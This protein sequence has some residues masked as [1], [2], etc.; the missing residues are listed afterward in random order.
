MALS[1]E[2]GTVGGGEGSG[3]AA[4]SAPSGIVPGTV[5]Q[6]PPLPPAVQVA[7]RRRPLL[8]LLTLLLLVLLGVAALA[9][10]FLPRVGGPAR[11]SGAAATWHRL[12]R[13][14]ASGGAGAAAPAVTER[15]S[16]AAAISA[17]RYPIARAQEVAS[18]VVARTAGNMADWRGVEKAAPAIPASSGTTDTGAAAV[19][20]P[21]AAPART[22]AKSAVV[23]SEIVLTAVM[24]SGTKSVAHINGEVVVTGEKSRAGV[25]L[26]GVYG[27]R[28]LLELDGEQRYVMVDGSRQRASQ[29][30]AAPKARRR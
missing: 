21:R 22:E 28:A 2:Q 30:A 14:R 19:P 18:Q 1:S 10:L 3:A 20:P 17:L 25:I 27:Q 24:G 9:T 11:L 26:K 6:P 16:A 23:W 7:A 5:A 8:P 12:L 4:R 29:P 13:M 15:P